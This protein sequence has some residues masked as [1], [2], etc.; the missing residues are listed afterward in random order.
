MSTDDFR[1]GCNKVLSTV[2]VMRG[3]LVARNVKD[4]RE[5]ERERERPHLLGLQPCNHHAASLH[6]GGVY[7]CP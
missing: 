6:L 2:K 1:T 4:E 5:R 7:L 3:P